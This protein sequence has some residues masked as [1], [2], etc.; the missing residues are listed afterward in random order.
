MASRVEWP[1]V[2]GGGRPA[3]EGGKHLGR[4]SPSTRWL[5]SSASPP[6]T[7]STRSVGRLP[8]F[9]APGWGRE[10]GWADSLPLADV[11]QPPASPLIAN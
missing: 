5:L 4:F 9:Y 11:H 6:P 2:G 7:P 10:Q 3:Y 1:Q 8:P